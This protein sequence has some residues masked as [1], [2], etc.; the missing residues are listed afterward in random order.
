VYFRF[1]GNYPIGDRLLVRS[2][3]PGYTLQL[4]GR[5]QLF[6]PVG[7]TAWAADLHLQYQYNNAQADDVLTVRREPVLVRSLHRWAVGV[8]IGQDMFL[9]GAGYVGGTW[10]ANFRLGWDAGLRLGTGHVDLNPLFDLNGYRRKQDTFWQPYVGVM[11]SMEMPI[12]GW[13]CF[14]GARLEWDWTMWNIVKESSFHE[15][16][17]LLMVGVRY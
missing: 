4:G 15:I 16:Q 10:D 5:S 3:N 6:E 7:D 12:G 9:D 8:G 2:L 17:A 11:A 14:G 1:G 13:T